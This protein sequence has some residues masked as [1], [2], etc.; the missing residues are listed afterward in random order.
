MR[1]AR[2]TTWIR[3]AV[4]TAVVCSFSPASA[5][6]DFLVQP[7]FAW[8]RNKETARWVTGGGV[9]LDWSRNWF[10]AG[11]EV[12]YASGFFD[13]EGDVT[14]LIESSHVLTVTG[15]AGVAM[16][17]RTE[18]DRFVPYATA[19]FGMLRQQARDRDGIIDVTRNDPSI[20][21]GGGVHVMLARFLGIRADF[22]HFRSTKD[23]FTT[24]DPIVSDLERLSFWR[25]GVGA[26]MRF[27]SY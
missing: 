17:V 14:D 1:R 2:L 6:A 21:F 24:P 12:G 18:E 10:I 23:P 26:V 3:T 5:H 22:R 13:P 20:H 11:G 9:T 15:H 8:T 4:L 7:F 27:G 19:G 16:P 25:I